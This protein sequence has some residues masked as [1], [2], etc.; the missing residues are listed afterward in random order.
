M[1]NNLKK[2]R[3][4]AKLSLEKL[5]EQCGLRKSSVWVLEQGGNVLLHNA[6][7]I[8]GTLHCTVQDIWPDETEFIEEVKIIKT[9]VRKP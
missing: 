3:K 8:A 9:R 4:E 2:L 5:G 6:Y 7:A 1:T